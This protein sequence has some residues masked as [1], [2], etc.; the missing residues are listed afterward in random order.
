MID[1]RRDHSWQ[2]PRPDLSIN[3]G[4]SNVCTQCHQD[5]DNSWADK[6]VGQWFPDSPYRN[7]SHFAVAFYAAEI[8]YQGV[9]ASLAYIAQDN[10]QSAI[11]RAS[12]LQRLA[13][14]T[15]AESL[16][17]L[18]KATKNQNELIRLGAIQG[19]SFTCLPC[20][21]EIIVAL[22]KQIRC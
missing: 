8:N 16:A 3:I 7:Q 12:S 4:T 19:S 14:Y 13:P 5:K 22:V 21:L 18:T 10:R 9:A 15:D 6:Q 17:V 2:I 1:K 20:T 11:I